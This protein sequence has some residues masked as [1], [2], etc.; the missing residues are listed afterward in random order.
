MKRAENYSIEQASEVLGRPV[1]LVSSYIRRGFLGSYKTRGFDQ[2]RVT[3]LDLVEFA[4]CFGARLRGLDDDRATD[5]VSANPKGLQATHR[6]AQGAQPLVGAAV[7]SK[8][9]PRGRVA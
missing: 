4:I 2:V 9:S 3:H 1:P 5:S 8:R 7:V 6:G